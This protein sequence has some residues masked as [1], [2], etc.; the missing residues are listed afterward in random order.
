MVWDADTFDAV[1]AELQFG[2]S[3][4]EPIPTSPSINNF[5]SVGEDVST[6][7]NS[8][9]EDQSLTEGYGYFGIPSLIYPDPVADSNQ[10][11]RFSFSQSLESSD[12]ELESGDEIAIYDNAGIQLC[13]TTSTLVTGPLLVG[14]G[15]YN[16]SLGLNIDIAGGVDYC[17]FNGIA[18]P[19]YAENNSVTIRIWDKSE[20]TDVAI[21]NSLIFDGIDKSITSLDIDSLSI[22]DKFLPNAIGVSK[23]YPNPFNPVTNIDFAVPS[24]QHVK[25]SVYDVSGSQIS[26]LNDNALAPGNHSITWDANRFSSGIYFIRFE[27]LGYQAV[28][29]IMLIK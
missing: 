18:L 11:M 4:S 1:E 20:D 17:S 14:T 15:T 26:V 21:L 2:T 6:I 7:S 8:S 25:L 22:D 27:S 9:P 13:D 28:H 16:Q 10:R 3:S 23:I 12:I 24:F 19:G 29:K 5:F